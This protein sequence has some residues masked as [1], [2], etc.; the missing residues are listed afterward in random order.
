MHIIKTY[1]FPAVLLLFLSCK[2][3]NLKQPESK[4][5]LWYNQPAN[6]SVPDDKNG[7]KDD[8]EWLKALPLGNG[9]LG[10]M[11]FGD[12]NHERIQLSEESMWS[13]SNQESDNPEAAGEQGKIRQLLFDGKYKEATE[14]TN[15]TQICK[16]EGSGHGNG[17]NVPF[18]CFQT[19]GDLWIDFENN[20]EY[21]NYYRELDLENAIVRINYTQDGV[22]YSR[23]IFISQP[24]QVMVA[25]FTADKPGQISFTCSMNRPERSETFTQNNQL[26]MK[27][28]LSSGKGGNGLEYVARLK[29]VNKNGKVSCEG[30]ELVVE[31]AD[32]VIL[33][34]SAS[35][36]YQ[37]KYPE[38]KGRDY[39]TIT[40]NNIEQ[41][42]QKSYNDLFA[43]HQKEYQGYFKRVSLDIA[44]GEITTVPTDERVRNFKQTLT[45]PH[46]AELL[47]QYGR[48]LL[49]SSSRPG[50]LPANLQGIWANKI[51]T[52]W[53]GDYHTDV[54]VEMNYWLAEVTNLP[55]IH[56]PLFELTESLVAPGEKTAATQYHK[57]GWVVHPITNVW[58]YTS[59]G[60]SASWGMHTGAGAWICSHIWEHFAF[61]GDK[62]FL[63]RMY[64][65]LRGSV[66]FYLDW[67]VEHPETKKLVSGPAVSPENTFVAPDGT[68]SQISMG[69]AHDQQVIWQL[70]TD[71][72]SA[73]NELNRDDEFIERIKNA[74]NRLAGPEIGSDGRLMEWAE[75]FPEVEPGHRHISHLFAIHPGSQISMEKTPQLAMAAK[76]SLDYRIENGGGHTGWSAAWLISQYARLHEAQKAKESL[77]TV[78]AK[79]TSPN[80]FGQHPPFQ[81]DAN[82]G[83]TAGIAEMLV[84]SHTG[85]VHLLPALP[86]EWS[87]GEVKGLR[88]RG[89]FEVDIKWE[90]GRLVNAGIKAKQDGVCMLKYRDNVLEINMKSGES[91]LFDSKLKEENRK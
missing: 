10:V 3:Q 89:N 68:R 28:A 33:Y 74:Q 61:T 42:T 6:A 43:A 90:N 1:F 58:G 11:V 57:K 44:P 4:L 80:L 72:I 27:G 26:V 79:S 65:V 20:P 78:I 2:T 84:Q 7:W 14:L 35:T 52:P 88:A 69:P 12:V 25:R 5:K 36:D 77:N 9:S 70:F 24:D 8:P 39:E 17:A 37:L 23:E 56:L 85:L 49:I 87:N 55:E 31:K 82:F 29:A 21:D 47:F 73:S 45:D 67:L 41:A 30:A 66:E 46:L 83:A 54:N 81:M 86:L 40:N 60:E 75:E 59:P 53:N 63:T 32:E 38:Y 64:P 51:Q 48:Y 18:G 13:G 22:N 91:K 62:E 76:K 50:T 19:L 16:G 34:L 15:K 71:F